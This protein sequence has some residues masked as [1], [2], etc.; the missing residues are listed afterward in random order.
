MELIEQVNRL[1]RAEKYKHKDPWMVLL[2][3]KNMVVTTVLKSALK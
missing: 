1:T 3:I 2:W